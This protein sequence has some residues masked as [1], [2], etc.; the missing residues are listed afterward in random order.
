MAQVTI[1]VVEGLERGRVYE[2]LSCPLT[3]GREDD[4]SVRLNDERVSR[5]HAK[6]QEDG[7]R[8]ILTD[9]DSTNGTRVNGHPV[10]MR[11]L[12]PGDQLSIG[13]C[14]LIYGSPAQIAERAMSLHVAEQGDIEEPG[15]RT[16]SAPAP[17]A[18][19]ADRMHDLFPGG[20]PDPP[21]DLGPRQRAE[22]SDFLSWVHEQIRQVM[23][24]TVEVK[25]ADEGDAEPLEMD[26]L[27]WQKLQK[28]EM[29][30]ARA[31]RTIAEPDR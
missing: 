7:G 5:F 29:D 2:D 3:I 13:R 19:L 27:A 10:Q 11:I 18:S 22:V 26:W 4:N 28:L 9:L 1:Q 16:L 12:Q 25:A 23:L 8:I 30:L 31:L 15:D 24:S 20:P 17:E 6:L 14:L 21:V